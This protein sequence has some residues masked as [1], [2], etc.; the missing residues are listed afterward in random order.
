MQSDI[1][2]ILQQA[3]ENYLKDRDIKLFQADVANLAKRLEIYELLRDREIEIF[4]PIADALLKIHPEENP[5]LI[6]K[7]LKHWLSIMRYCAMA[8]LLNNP[9][10]LQRGVLEW[11]TDMVQAHQMQSIENAIYDLLSS[12]L[13][14]LLSQDQFT[15]IEPFL[16]QT[17]AILGDKITST[18][19]AEK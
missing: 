19:G 12:D 8:T 18:V 14:R 16:E 11:V 3:E 6:E 9:E 1:K 5:Q 15:L 13:Q 17:Q 2:N 10:Y 4:Q 7:A